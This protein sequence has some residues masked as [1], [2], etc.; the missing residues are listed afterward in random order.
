MSRQV[1]SKPT[2]GPARRTRAHSQTLINSAGAAAAVSKMTGT[3][4]PNM[5]GSNTSPTE[6]QAEKIKK[7]EKAK[8]IAKGKKVQKPK[9]R[10]DTFHPFPRLPNEIKAMILC[11]YIDFE[12]AI[13]Y[14]SCEANKNVPGLIDVKTGKD[15]RHSKYKCIAELTKGIPDFKAYIER[16]IGVS[17]HDLS[18][19][20]KEGVRKDKD[21]MVL[22]FNKKWST[23]L[24]WY[25]SSRRIL[26]RERFVPDIEN[27]GVMYDPSR[28][29][30]MERVDG[31]KSCPCSITDLGMMIMN[32][33][34]IRN[35]YI[36]VKLRGRSQSEQKQWMKKRLRIAKR[37]NKDLV[38]FEDKQRTWVE[39][40]R[41]TARHQG[42]GSL[43]RDVANF[44]RQVERLYRSICTMCS[45]PPNVR[46]RILV[47]SHFLNKTL[48]I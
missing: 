40:T 26:N 13:I 18:Y 5:K 22:I 46:F 17:F 4:I 31:H 37:P 36:L 11:E 14:A 35:F 48:G 38:V 32:L 20:P 6:P 1:I 42:D 3:A 15:G 7:V 16:Q 21:L 25:S 47:A 23:H 33:R 12:P 10:F 27:I 44:V 2:M 24:S 28:L 34:D 30:G 41:S 8:Q 29:R 43:L 19:R 45:G 39:I 9:P